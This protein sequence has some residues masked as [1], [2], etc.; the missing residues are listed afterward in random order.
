GLRVAAADQRDQLGDDLRPDRRGLHHGLRHHRHDQLRPRRRLHDRRLRGP[1]RPVAAPARRRHGRNGRHPPHAARLRR[2]HRSVRVDGGTGRLP[3]PARLLPPRA[4]DLR[5]RPL[6][7]VAELR[8]GQPGRA[9][10]AGG[11]GAARRGGGVP[12]GRFRGAALLHADAHHRHHACRAGGLHHPGHAHA[13]RPGHARLRAGPEDGRAS[14]HRHRPDH[15]P[16]LRHRRGLGGGGGHH[17]PAALRRDRLLHRLPRRG[18]GLH[19]GRPRRHRLAPRRGA[20]RPAHR[21]DRDLLERLF[22]RAVQGR[23]RLLH[24]GPHPDLPAHRPARPAGGRE[25]M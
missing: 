15:Q 22:Q 6:H 25:G 12:R 7:R 24:P 18:E 21:P 4:A 8:A 16:H 13:A 19:R 20:R 9:R 3:A 14:R 2:R 10:Q 23:R 5:H 1:H 17:V 11:S